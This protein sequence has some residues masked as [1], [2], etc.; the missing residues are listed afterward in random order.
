MFSPSLSCGI[1]VCLVQPKDMQESVRQSNLSFTQGCV[2]VIFA[3]NH[4][5]KLK[6]VT[7][8]KTGHYRT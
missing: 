3:L 1:N 7:D 5:P 2:F 6:K 8:F 4:L